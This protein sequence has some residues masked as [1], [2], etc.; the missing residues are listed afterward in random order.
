MR[1]VAFHSVHGVYLGHRDGK[2]LFSLRDRKT[3][4]GDS[5]VTAPTFGGRAEF[6]EAA[7]NHIPERMSDASI[8]LACE[9]REVFPR[10]NDRAGSMECAQAG[11]PGWGG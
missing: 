5:D 8:L 4:E 1:Y 2:P 7:G 6:A 10:H 11:M 9:M 3:V